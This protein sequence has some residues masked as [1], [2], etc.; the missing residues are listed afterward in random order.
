MSL[1]YNEDF[2]RNIP[3]T[4]LSNI[5]IMRKKIRKEGTWSSPHA[6]LPTMYL[7]RE[8]TVI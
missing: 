5:T 8:V 1:V 2:G 7:S 3:T 4:Q 6:P